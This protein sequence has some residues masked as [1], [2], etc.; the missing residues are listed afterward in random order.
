[1]HTRTVTDICTHTHTHMPTTPTDVSHPLLKIREKL[2]G[3]LDV[4]VAAAMVGHPLLCCDSDFPPESPRVRGCG[5]NTWG[6]TGH[7]DKGSGGGRKLPG[8]EKRGVRRVLSQRQLYHPVEW[9]VWGRRDD[10]LLRAQWEHGESHRSWTHQ[11]ASHA[12][13]RSSYYRGE[14]LL[15]CVEAIREVNK[16]PCTLLYPIQLNISGHLKA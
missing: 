8:S 14:T 16:V 3:S 12:S 11:A 5:C 10:V 7:P 9:G 2:S 1:M 13:G 6:G 15:I 4:S